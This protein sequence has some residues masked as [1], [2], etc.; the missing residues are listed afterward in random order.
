[1]N[2]KLTKEHIR[3]AIYSNPKF[4]FLKNIVCDLPITEEKPYKYDPAIIIT[5]HDDN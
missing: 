3:E 5:K 1:M 4:T 2:Y